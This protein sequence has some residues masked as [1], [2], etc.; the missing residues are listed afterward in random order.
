MT[1]PPL[2]SGRKVRLRHLDPADLPALHRLATDPQVRATWRTRGDLWSFA[3]LEHH[4][5]ADPHVGL[6]VTSTDD[7]DPIGLIELHDVDLIDARAQLAV[8]IAPAAWASGVAGEAAVLFARFAFDT[9]P[10]DKLACTVQATNDRAVSSLRRILDHEGT[11][12]RHLNVHGDWIDL[13]LFALWRKD[14]SVIE[15]RLGLAAAY[16]RLGGRTT[17]LSELREILLGAGISGDRLDQLTFADLDSLAVLEVVL[18]TEDHI[19]R[20]IAIEAF[21][22]EQRVADL[23]VFAGEEHR[24]V[25]A[26]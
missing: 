21:A 15:A 14:L 19:G 10:L 22:L 7:Q 17:L 16:E 23:L 13:D 12:R 26:P 2:R 11:L 9:L 8:L 25:Q 24:S 20:P 1:S 3:Q 18:A 4:L 6:V 5:A